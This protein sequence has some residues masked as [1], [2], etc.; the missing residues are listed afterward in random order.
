MIAKFWAQIAELKQ[1]VPTSPEIVSQDSMKRRLQFPNSGKYGGTKGLPK[2][3]RTREEPNN[4]NTERTL[5]SE[6][7]SALDELKD[8]LRRR[9]MLAGMI[10]MKN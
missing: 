1:L 10:H 2:P 7:L 5:L 3:R 6:Q 4:R 9:P 8:L